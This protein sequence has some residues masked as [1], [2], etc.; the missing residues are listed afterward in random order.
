MV[1]W[2][3]SMLIELDGCFIKIMPCDC[4]ATRYII[5]IIAIERIYLKFIL[6]N[7]IESYKHL[8]YFSLQTRI[9]TH[10]HTFAYKIKTASRQHI[11]PIE[12]TTIYTDVT[13]HMD[14]QEVEEHPKTVL[15]LIKIKIKFYSSVTQLSVLMLSDCSILKMENAIAIPLNAFD[16]FDYIIC[17]FLL[18]CR[19]AT[20]LVCILKVLA[21]AL[22]IIHWQWLCQM[23]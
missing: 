3:H 21:G 17:L 14:Q 10:T 8:M 9:H 7:A 1:N 20:W 15:N 22:N 6:I 2:D 13:K 4:W 12:R 19:A 23:F 16:A 18:L 5:Y 11:W